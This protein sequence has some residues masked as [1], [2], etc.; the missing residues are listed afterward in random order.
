MGSFDLAV[1]KDRRGAEAVERDLLHSQV[2][3]LTSTCQQLQMQV[4]AL[5]A[6]VTELTPKDNEPATSP[7]DPVA[8]TPADALA[9]SLGAK[10]D[11][12]RASVK[13]PVGYVSP[14]GAS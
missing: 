7:T 10:P 8:D 3:A 6:K 13:R 5:R 14:Y 1:L 2:V 11:P 4:A 9:A 12:K